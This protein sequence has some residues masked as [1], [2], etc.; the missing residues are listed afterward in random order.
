MNTARILINNFI[1]NHPVDAAR[2]LERLNI[3]D[4]ALFL[5][6]I[7][8]NLA[9]GIMS[10]LES[11]TA[12]KCLEKLSSKQ[13]A[14]I[15]ERLPLQVVSIFL[16]QVREDI[17]EK[18]LSLVNKEISIPLRKMLNYSEESAGALA[19]P[20]VLTL[21]QDITVK[22][23]LQRVNERT[24][25][26]IYYL[27]ILNRKQSLTGVINLRELLAAQRGDQ[28]SAIMHRE[29]AYISAEFYLY[30]I[31]NHPGWQEYHAMP[32]TEESG[33]FL[34]AIRYETLRRIE[35]ES[36]KS[37]LPRQVIAASNAL[38]ELY[39]I[40]FSGLIRSATTP[41]KDPYDKK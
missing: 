7:S 19:D 18:I 30:D 27:Y 34:G 23:A 35:R 17:R 29:V 16:R 20:L 10:S 9:A 37:P 2:I 22:E 41:L 1:S 40:G 5:K 8:A 12:A 15:L 31:F 11:Y 32:V 24:E 26:T 28:L 36:K 4:T 3:E 39:Q 13:A 33:M 14:I 38:G 25:K 6:D 21:P